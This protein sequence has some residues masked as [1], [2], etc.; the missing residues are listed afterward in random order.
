MLPAISG[1]HC[2]AS[3]A[4]GEQA[5]RRKV[6]DMTQLLSGRMRTSATLVLICFLPL[7]ARCGEEDDASD[8]SRIR[9]LA[10]MDWNEIGSPCCIEFSK[11]GTVAVGGWLVNGKKTVVTV[12]DL[13]A[14]QKVATHTVDGEAIISVA[15][16][17]NG[18][19]LAFVSIRS[20]FVGVGSAAWICSPLAQK[21]KLLLEKDDLSAVVF[22]EHDEALGVSRIPSA[23]AIGLVNLSNGQDF[24][25]V[26]LDVD[27]QLCVYAMSHD[28]KVLAVGMPVGIGTR[29]SQIGVYELPSGRAKKTLPPKRTRCSALKFAPDGLAIAGAFDD[30]TVAIWDTKT[31]LER[32][33]VRPQPVDEE[34]RT[35]YSLAFAAG[36]DLLAIGGWRR[37][38]LWDTRANRVVETLDGPGGF[39]VSSSIDGDILGA[40]SAN[41]EGSSM[42]KFWEVV[43]RDGK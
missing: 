3:I 38:T 17:A 8:R 24:A 12:W 28:L 34:T 27:P 14:R 22:G 29:G 2:I 19:Q 30:G 33:M 15:F 23:P 37:M 7:D 41:A 42:I 10:A 5:L 26:S 13:G 32:L 21:P 9:L 16:T 25:R 4:C 11:S 43:N 6:D 35:I 36:G 31:G 39:R 20:V 40:L 1:D 18:K